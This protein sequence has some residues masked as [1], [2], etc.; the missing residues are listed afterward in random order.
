MPS[1]DPARR[2]ADIVREIDLILDMTAG[3][4]LDDIGGDLKTLRAV[5][6][7]FQIISEAAAKLGPEAERLCPDHEWRKIRG[8][9]NVLRH[10][11]DNVELD[12]LWATIDDG[13]LRRMRADCLA[14][15][16]TLSGSD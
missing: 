3:K 15:I 16:R 4:S 5:E 2:F 12:I 13:R 7:C 6:R 14:A 10:G 11:Y 9:G 8:F 1:S